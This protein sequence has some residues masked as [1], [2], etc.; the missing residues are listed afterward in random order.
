MK[1]PSLQQLQSL[2]LSALARDHH[3]V[4]EM[5]AS[6]AETP[7]SLVKELM[8]THGWPAHEA[9]SAVRQLLEKALQETSEQAEA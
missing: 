3:V 8:D 6:I 7:D 9:L 2:R 1:Q 5:N 4:A